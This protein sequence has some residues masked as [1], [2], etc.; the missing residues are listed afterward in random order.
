MIVDALRGFA[1]LGIVVVNVWFFAD[2]Y[3]ASG[4]TNPTMAGPLDQTI[5]GGVTFFFETKFYLLFSFL[6]GISL[7]LQAASAARS[8]ASFGARMTRRQIGLF[9]IGA[10]HC[11]LLYN[12]DILTTYALTG[13]AV[14]VVANTGWLT[15]RRA[16]KL[17]VTVVVTWGLLLAALGVLQ[18]AAD[19]N[20][21]RPFQGGRDLVEAFHGTALDTL[22]FH[23]TSAAES[24]V[25]IML[26]QG[27]M[28]F[29]MML[30]GY[31]AGEVGLFS[32]LS[33][34]SAREL[35]SAT[36]VRRLLCVGFPLSLAGAG[37]YTYT[38]D[39][40]SGEAFE[41]IGYGI[42]QLTAPIQTAAYV[43]LLTALFCS[44]A[45]AWL[46]H[47]LAP[48]GK[49]ALSSYVLQSV[50]LN[51]VFTGY[52][53]GL[54]N[55]LSAAECLGVAAGIFVAHVIAAHWWVRHF[56]YGPAEW[57]LRWLTNAKRPTWRRVGGTQ[58]AS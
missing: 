5:R 10:V 22:T 1:L 49:V 6:F 56:H 57:G 27:V 50:L 46:V 3:F 48:V 8:G 39:F 20:A 47:V 12:G 7:T 18:F 43:V 37:I 24:I 33:S 54:A 34:M 30:V 9:L 38:N 29:A 26:L 14:L 55:R 32:R 19:G 44:P 53:L 31:A 51:L 40:A 13:S 58:K 42:D 15:P 21:A 4:H 41:T 11:A 28:A 36:R 45:G 25:G 16:I 2:S 52:G 17:A 35:L 23:A